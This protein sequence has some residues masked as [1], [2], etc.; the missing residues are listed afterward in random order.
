VELVEQLDGIPLALATAG[1]YLDQTAG[2][3]SDYLRLYRES[4]VRLTETSPELSSYEN[5]T[6]HSTWQISFDHIKQQND[7][8]ARLFQTTLNNDSD[9]DFSVTSLESFNASTMASSAT[10]ISDIALIVLDSA[11]EIVNLLIKD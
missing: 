11:T 5:R 8:A 3:F 9:S 1:A 2:S 4:W 7:L 10:L 6:I